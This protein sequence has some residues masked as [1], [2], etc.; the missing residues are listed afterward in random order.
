MTVSRQT[1]LEYIFEAGRHDF[2]LDVVIKDI[3]RMYARHFMN[4][5]DARDTI[6]FIACEQFQHEI[7][8]FERNEQNK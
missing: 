2:T 4:Y 5:A 6:S 8:E 7:N 1:Q 3:A